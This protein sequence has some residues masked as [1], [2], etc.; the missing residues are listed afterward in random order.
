MLPTTQRRQ[1]AFPSL[2]ADG[3]VVTRIRGAVKATPHRDMKTRFIAPKQPAWSRLEPLACVAFEEAAYSGYDPGTEPVDKAA[4]QE[5]KPSWDIALD[6]ASYPKQR[7]PDVFR[8]Q[9][10]SDGM[11]SLHDVAPCR[12]DRLRFM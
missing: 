6:V 7:G 11:M 4:C 9:R 1:Q 2:A 8:R 10:I 3:G 12:Q 5:F